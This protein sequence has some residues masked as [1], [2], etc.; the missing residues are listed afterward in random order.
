MHTVRAG[1]RLVFVLGSGD[2]VGRS[3]SLYSPIVTLHANATAASSQLVLP[4]AGGSVGGVEPIAAFPPR[5][6]A[7]STLRA[8]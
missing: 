7:P 4:V 6:F 3:G 2:A 8:S 5:P 1:H